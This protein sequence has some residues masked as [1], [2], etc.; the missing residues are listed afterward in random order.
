MTPEFMRRYPDY[1]EMSKELESQIAEHRKKIIEW[2]KK[3]PKRTVIE[4]FKSKG[5]KY[6][7]DNTYD[8][9]GR[10]VSSSLTA[11]GTTPLEGWS[12]QFHSDDRVD[13]VRFTDYEELREFVAHNSPN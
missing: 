1:P 5:K 10:L 4:Y 12:I 7:S 11:I 3:H 2:K 8:D 6:R 9:A 13:I